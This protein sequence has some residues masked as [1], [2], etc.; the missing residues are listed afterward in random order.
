MTRIRRFKN[1]VGWFYFAQTVAFLLILGYVM[2]QS[3]K[4]VGWLLLPP[5][6]LLGVLMPYPFRDFLVDHV[7]RLHYALNAVALAGLLFYLFGPRATGS[8]PLWAVMAFLLVL[9]LHFG[10]AFWAYSDWRVTRR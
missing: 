2:A 5:A 3:L 6:F 8:P 9:G 4:P 7:N 10:C 1:N